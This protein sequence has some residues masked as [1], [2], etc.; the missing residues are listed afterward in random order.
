MIVANRGAYSYV[1]VLDHR[2]LSSDHCIH[3]LLHQFSPIHVRS[4]QMPSYISQLDNINMTKF[5]QVALDEL[6]PTIPISVWIKH[7]THV[8]ASAAAALTSGGSQYNISSS[9]PGAGRRSATV[10]EH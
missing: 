8:S 4:V 3:G 7:I 9:L 2:L 6:N 5:F 1:W 10:Y